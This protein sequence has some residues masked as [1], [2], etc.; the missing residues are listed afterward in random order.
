MTAAAPVITRKTKATWPG[1]P[2]PAQVHAKVVLPGS[3]HDSNAD[4]DSE[5]SSEPA[6]SAP[7]LL[8]EL[9]VI[10]M[11]SI[12]PVILAALASGEPLLLIG[13]HGTAKSYLLNRIALALG[14][15]WR[16]YN[17]SLLNFDDLVGYP[18][19]DD[20]GSLQYVETPSS[21][22]G[23]EAVFL[24][25]ISRCRIDLQNKLFPII[26]ERR[27]QGIELERLVYRWSAMNPPATDDDDSDDAVTNYRGSEP[28]DPALADR[29]A[30]VVEMPPWDSFSADDQQRVIL[31][32]DEPSQPEISQRLTRA[33]QATRDHL[34]VL[35]EELSAEL[36][37]YVQVVVRMLRDAGLDLS[38]RR[39]GILWR[40]I[41]A[42]H[43]AN[44]V[45]DPRTDPAE[46]ALLALNNSIPQRAMG[47]RVDEIRILAAH[48]EAWQ[49]VGLE[50][51][52]PLRMVLIETDP[53]R[54]ALRAAAVGYAIPA[55]DFSAM[56]ADAI[57]ALPNGG[58]HALTA[59]LFESQAAGRLVATVADQCAALYSVV[60]TPQQAK[61][62]VH[63]GDERHLAWQQITASLA[64]LEKETRETVA[65]TNLLVGLF[66]ADELSDCRD[67]LATVESWRSV[68]DLAHGDLL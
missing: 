61:S 6:R 22:W 18:L 29:F 50:P 45:H 11:T 23:A 54:R 5:S 35:R 27:V 3:A 14:L 1:E 40:N 8:T 57:A 16:H 68:R 12:E 9:G 13:P 39:A 53:L 20:Q 44:L 10:G 55:P 60:A 64:S 49:L 34:P 65:L 37:S 52:N 62:F 31:A 21:I 4:T 33:V 59:V 30:F 63:S 58:R 67:V 46:S 25:E 66:N 32:R 41:L 2:E 17:A 24:D 56:V 43:A 28:L 48:R 51:T 47:L 7:S 38:P 36:S 19:P 15:E 26:H 42:I